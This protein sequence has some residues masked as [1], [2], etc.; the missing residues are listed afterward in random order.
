VTHLLELLLEVL[1]DFDIVMGQGG[2]EGAKCGEPESL[3]PK[4]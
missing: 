2:W 4:I 1:D 3:R